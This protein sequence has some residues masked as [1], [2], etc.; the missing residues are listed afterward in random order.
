VLKDTDPVSE[1]IDSLLTKVV[2]IST[3]KF[4]K[5]L[6]KDIEF[7]RTNLAKAQEL[8]DIWIKVQKYMQQQHQIFVYEDIRKQLASEYNKYE[9][10]EKIWKNN[11]D[12]VRFSPQL[13]EVCQIIKLKENLLFS[14]ETLENVNKELNSYL[15]T[16]RDAFPRFY[17]ISNEE[18]LVILAQSGDPLIIANSYIQQSFEGI[19]KLGVTK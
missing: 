8:I 18:L 6:Q 14:L 3:S 4:A 10:V 5:Y 7:I 19:K 15:N 16:K 17:F 1:E 11:M 13:T 12:Q 9:N 2:S